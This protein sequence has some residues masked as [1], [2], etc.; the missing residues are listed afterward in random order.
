MP[1]LKISRP[2]YKFKIPDTARQFETDPHSL[3][4]RPCTADEERQASEV[5]MGSK[6][7]LPFELL[8]RSVCEV[9]DKPVD[10]GT[11]DPEWLERASP[12]VRELAYRA[13]VRVNQPTQEEA[14]GFFAGMET[15]V[16]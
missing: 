2:Q 7:P 6:A 4:L 15:V 9:D 16:G 12:K 3:T 14:D 13:F 11:A 8:R 10:W 1:Q 5:A